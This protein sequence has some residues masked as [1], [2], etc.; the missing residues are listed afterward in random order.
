[1]NEV[2]LLAAVF[3]AAQLGEV[4]CQKYPDADKVV[5]EE[6]EKVRYFPDGTSETVEESWTK[7]L[8]EK[9]RRGE[10]VLRL[11]Y[12][13]RYGE[14]AIEY[15]GV[16]AAD[17]SERE[18]DVSAT[19]KE[20]TDNS[21]MSA[22]IYDPLDRVIICT[23]PGLAIGD[24]LHVKT[25]RKVLKPR[26]EGK[27]SDLSLLEWS[28]PILRST[29]EVTAPS[30]LPLRKI[31]IRNPIGNVTTNFNLL[32]DGSAVYT[33]TA[34]NSA[35]AFPEPDMPPLYTQVQRVHVSTALSWSEISKW[36][37]NLCEPHLAKTNEALVAKA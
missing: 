18:I 11:D 26:C 5:I 28:S 36:Y 34:T 32:A 33:F 19:T 9:G 15:V 12:S 2:L 4:N 8:T 20:S 6:T 30:E 3:T 10:S 14:A 7:L 13:K 24:T 1:M 37:W 25:R 31:A 35:Q 29:Y 27:W 17:G 21:S 16:V 22:N 23:I